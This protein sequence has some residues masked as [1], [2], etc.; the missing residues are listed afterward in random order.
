MGL[1]MKLNRNSI[2]ASLFLLLFNLVITAKVNGQASGKFES[3]LQ[4]YP[5]N[6]VILTSLKQEL[7]IEMSDGKPQLNLKEDKEYLALNDNANF[8][9]I[10]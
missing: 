3:Y 6:S 4:K 8:V 10:W 9:R 1:F 7:V 5:N 2:L